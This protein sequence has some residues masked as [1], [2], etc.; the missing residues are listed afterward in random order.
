MFFFLKKLTVV[1]IQNGLTFGYTAQTLNLFNSH[2][3]SNARLI[4]YFLTHTQE[5]MGECFFFKKLSVVY[6]FS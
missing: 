6:N 4:H 2:S 1:Y 5:E 3:F